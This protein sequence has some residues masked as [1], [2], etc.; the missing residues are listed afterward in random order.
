MTS[1]FSSSQSSSPLLIYFIYLLQ[2]SQLAS[3]LTHIFESVVLVDPGLC[4]PSSS[5][6]CYGETIP[7]FLLLPVP[8]IICSSFGLIPTA[9]A[10]FSKKVILFNC[11]SSFVVSGVLPAISLPLL[12]GE[13]SIGFASYS[14]VFGFGFDSVNFFSTSSIL[15]SGVSRSTSA[16]GA[17]FLISSLLQLHLYLLL[18]FVTPRIHLTN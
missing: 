13:N 4:S 15:C 9:A 17:I 10:N 3:H 5:R 6:R 1:L 7:K 18:F 16:T 12:I 2:L 11:E 14:S 8:F